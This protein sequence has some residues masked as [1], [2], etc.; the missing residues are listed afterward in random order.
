MFKVAIAGCGLIAVKKHIPAFLSIKNKVRISAVCDLNQALVK[1]AAEN[2]NI[3]KAYASF[4][5]MLLEEK[6]DIVDICTPPQTHA[7]LAVLALECGAHAFIEKPMALVT[8][9]CDRMIDAAKKYARKICIVHNQI[10]NPAFIKARELVTKGEVG[11]FLGMRILMSTPADYM[12]SKKDHWAHRLPGGV[13]GETGPHAVYLAEA[14]L[15]NI[16]TADVRARK[17]LPEYPWSDFEDFRINLSAEN[18]TCSIML[19]YGSNQWA[20]NLDILG[21]RGMLKIDLQAQ[22]V[23]KYKRPD[24]GAVTIGWSELS[25]LFQTSGS[26]CMNGLKHVLGKRKDAHRQA[27]RQFVDSILN[28]APLPITASEGRETVRVMEMI[29]EK[30]KCA[31]S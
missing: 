9:D 14:I 2:F 27:I 12:T 10:F 21:T 4:T 16:H 7:D 24:L 22:A 17:I 3:R 30:L 19:A 28:N 26:L 6:P 20:A 1:K 11:D 31:E 5:D 23:T 15:K 25:K 29:I 18:G 8:Q 13:L